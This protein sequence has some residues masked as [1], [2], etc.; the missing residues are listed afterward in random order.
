MANDIS[1]YTKTCFAKNLSLQS[2]Y[3]LPIAQTKL[4]SYISYPF[5]LKNFENNFLNS[6]KVY[7]AKEFFGSIDDVWKLYNERLRNR[8]DVSIPLFLAIVL[9]RAKNREDIGRVI[10]ELRDE[11]AS[12]RQDLWSIYDQL[13]DTSI[14][15]KNYIQ[16]LTDVEVS[17]KDILQSSMLPNSR[18][19]LLLS[20]D[21]QKRFCSMLTAGVSMFDGGYTMIISVINS[22]L[23]SLS[24][25]RSFNITAAQ[26]TANHVHELDYQGLLKKMLTER[27]QYDLK[28]SLK[29]SW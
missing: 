1:D 14:S 16:L 7:Q 26:L 25:G 28:Q 6:E 23:N 20:L 18:A 15:D 8:I 19:K 27:E 2:R 21:N 29:S 3:I 13:D 5:L 4:S 17:T 24:V 10:L 22:I 11:Y 12:A 9:S